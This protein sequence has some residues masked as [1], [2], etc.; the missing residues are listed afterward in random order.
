MASTPFIIYTY[1]YDEKS[2][3]ALLLHYL[4]HYL[5]EAGFE[6]FVWHSAKPLYSIG[7]F[8]KR[9]WYDTKFSFYR[10]FKI[11][12]FTNRGAKGVAPAC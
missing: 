8:H 10:K 12:S 9:F 2:G 7:Q 5:N 4:C 1:R 3:G 6:A 11:K